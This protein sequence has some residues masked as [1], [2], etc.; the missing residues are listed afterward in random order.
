MS[1]CVNSL[2]TGSLVL[3]TEGRHIRLKWGD[4]VNDLS[5]RMREHEENVGH[6]KCRYGIK[7]IN[8]QSPLTPGHNLPPSH[9]K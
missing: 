3:L 6:Y 5:G 4:C 2:S 8:L 9:E 1:I 7:D